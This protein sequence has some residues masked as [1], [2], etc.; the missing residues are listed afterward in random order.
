MSNLKYLQNEVNS[1]NHEPKGDA[2]SYEKGDMSTKRNMARG[3]ASFV[4]AGKAMQEV[5]IKL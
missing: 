1:A 5:M 3:P 4:A 2:N